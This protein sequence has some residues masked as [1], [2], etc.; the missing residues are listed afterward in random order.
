MILKVTFA[1]SVDPDQ[2]SPLVVWNKVFEILGHLLYVT[3]LLSYSFY[4]LHT[5]RNTTQWH[6]NT[7]DHGIKLQ[8]H[9]VDIK[10][11][12]KKVGYTFIILCSKISDIFSILL[13]QEGQLSV[14]S[15]RTCTKYWAQFK[16]NNVLRKCVVKTLIIKYGIYA[17]IFAEKM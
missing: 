14:S 3:L 16:T 6:Q 10:F 4:I 13:I 17:N 1:N 5:N 8:S 2:T 9:D 11:Q 12:S 7:L 15:E